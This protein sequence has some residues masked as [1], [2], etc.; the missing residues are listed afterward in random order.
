MC[1]GMKS[2]CEREQEWP[3]ATLGCTEMPSGHQL[4][5]EQDELCALAQVTRS[6]GQSGGPG[7]TATGSQVPSPSEPWRLAWEVEFVERSRVHR[8]DLKVS[9]LWKIDDI[10]IEV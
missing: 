3:L 7:R 4:A 9:H 10:F 5:S 6:R 2:S 1:E 8:R